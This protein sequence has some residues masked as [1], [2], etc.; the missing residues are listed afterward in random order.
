MSSNRLSRL[1]L[2]LV[3]DC[4]YPEVGQVVISQKV[5]LLQ[6]GYLMEHEHYWDT[7]KSETEIVDGKE[8]FVTA[9]CACG[10]KL[11]RESSNS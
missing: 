5:L 7:P 1:H 11:Y 6:R 9:E 4:L 10:E 3:Q 2:D 8:L